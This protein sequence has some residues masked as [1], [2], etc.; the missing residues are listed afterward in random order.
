MTFGDIV[1]SMG[2]SNGGGTCD[3][4]DPA[5]LM[6]YLLVGGAAFYAVSL[7]MVGEGVVEK[8]YGGRALKRAAGRVGRAFGG[9]S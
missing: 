1:S 6:F 8:G 2:N 5:M 3:S 7:Y 4:W 9:R